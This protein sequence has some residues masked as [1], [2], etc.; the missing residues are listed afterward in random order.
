MET[1]DQHRTGVILIVLSA[2]VFSLAGVFTKAITAGSWEIVFW[3]GI[4][5][6]CFMLGYIFLRKR[7]AVEV[8]KMGW[9]GVTIGIVGA[10]ASACFIA[11]FKFTTIANVILIY[12]SLPIIAALLAWL[13]AGE[14]P[15]V[16]VLLGCVGVFAGVGIIVRE[17]LGSANLIGVLLALGMTIGMSVI[18]VIYRRWPDTPAA[19]P[20]A[21]SSVLLIPAGIMFGQVA[22]VSRPDLLL[23]I[24]FGLTFAIAA[25]AV[26]EGARRV[27]A[28]QTA[29]L[30]ALETPLAP[31]LGFLFFA[32]IPTLATWIGGGLILLAVVLSQLPEK[33]REN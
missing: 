27:P 5:S 23:L 32:E 14:K 21:L 11:A 15:T 2:V 3:R 12:A 4:F 17:S 16:R 9:S 30:S 20:A 26:S 18:M 6:T 10:A 1:G 31:L 28:G 7:F 24:G 29:L 22:S 19:G 13:F 8:S 33:R 25:V